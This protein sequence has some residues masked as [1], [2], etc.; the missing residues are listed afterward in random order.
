MFCARVGI[1]GEFVQK[2]SSIQGITAFFDNIANIFIWFFIAKLNTTVNYKL[3][4]T[5]KGRSEKYV[6]FAI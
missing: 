2:K 4:R 1:V 3:W 5:Q 6:F